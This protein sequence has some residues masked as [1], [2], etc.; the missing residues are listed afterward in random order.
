MSEVAQEKMPDTRTGFSTKAKVFLGLVE[1]IDLT[2]R[3]VKWRFHDEYSET[4]YDSLIV[5]AGAGQS[6]FGNDQFATFAPGM[7]STL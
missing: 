4:P 5:A 3:V 1:D 6:Y 2:N 7:K